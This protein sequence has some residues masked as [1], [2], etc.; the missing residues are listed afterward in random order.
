MPERLQFFCYV[1][2]EILG[3]GGSGPSRRDDSLALLKIARFGNPVL[4]EKAV[5]V[6]DPTSDDMRRLV[7]DMIETMLDVGGAGLA[8][9]QVHR[10]LSMFVYH[11]PKQRA[12]DGAPLSP[13]ALFNPTLFPVG[14]KIVPCVEGCLSLPGMR[15][16]VPRYARIRFE[17]MDQNGLPVSGEASGF[18]ANVLQ[19]EADHLDGVLYTSRILDFA[20]F[21]YAEELARYG[22]DQPTSGAETAE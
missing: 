1:G 17:G 22:V 10:S 13:R 2:I 6:P 4:L 20:S 11:V 7:E 3:T 9:P 19:H 14:D 8:A 5:P 12:G 16:T 15:G 18:H 21:G